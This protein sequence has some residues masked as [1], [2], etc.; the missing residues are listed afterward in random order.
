MRAADCKP[1]VGKPGG[2]SDSLSPT[3]LRCSQAG[4]VFVRLSPGARRVEELPDLL[5]IVGKID[6]PLPRLARQAQLDHVRQLRAQTVV[7]AVEVIED[8]RR[9]QLPERNTRHHLRDLLER[10]RAARKGDERIA[11]L[12]HLRLALRK[13]ARDDELGQ[14]VVQ[15]ALIHKNLRLD[16]RR[17]A[18]RGEHALGERAHE[19]VFRPAIDERVAALADP[20][21]ERAH[22]VAQC[23]VIA[24]VRA[25]IDRS[26]CLVRVYSPEFPVI[27]TSGN[28]CWIFCHC[29]GILLLAPMSC[30]AHCIG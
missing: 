11:Q 22:R 5:E 30:S 23:G 20:A 29:K 26:V 4:G 19:P 17:P 12:Q 27:L 8:A 3:G 24:R 15:K 2:F 13:V 14:L 28:S 9:V 7:V 1:F 25:Q 6:A 18:A 21:A 16:A 10:A